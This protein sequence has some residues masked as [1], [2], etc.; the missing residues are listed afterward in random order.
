MTNAAVPASADMVSASA[1]TLQDAAALHAL[2]EAFRRQGYVVVR[3]L[4][5]PSVCDAIERVAREQLKS[6]VAPLEYEAELGYPGA[7]KSR[8]AVG[9]GTVRRLRQAYDRDPV[10]RQWATEEPVASLV[11]ALLGEPARLTLAHHN[12]VMTKHPM[13]GSQTGWH[14]DTRYWSFAQPELVTVWLALGH[15]D[16][17]NG[18]LRVIPRSHLASLQPGQLDAAE[19]LV[20]S[21]PASAPLLADTVSL[22]LERGDVLCFDSRLFHSAGQNHSDMVKL[23]VAF[24]YLGAGNA[25]VPGTRSAQSPVV[26]L[27]VKVPRG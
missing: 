8:D 17:S 5:A 9:G 10:F 27:P 12:C 19:F 15:E 18:G 25:P 3:G 1:T 13:Y 7:P 20:E 22:T 24:A 4:A 2:A 14:R 21:H 11:T 6:A 26:D 23:S 16:E